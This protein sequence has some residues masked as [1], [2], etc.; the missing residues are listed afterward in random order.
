[1]ARPGTMMRSVWS[2]SLRE[3]QV[4][5]AEPDKRFHA[6]ESVSEGEIGA[7]SSL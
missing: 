2:E 5:F 1:M 7:G 4:L 3:L 6:A